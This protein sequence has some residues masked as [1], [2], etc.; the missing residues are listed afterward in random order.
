MK[1]LTMLFLMVLFPIISVAGT[2]N[3]SIAAAQHQAEKIV[4][5]QEKL[6]KPLAQQSQQVSQRYQSAVRQ[7]LLSASPN[8]SPLHAHNTI[9]PSPQ[10]IL[11][12]SL[13]MPTPLLR[14]YL[15]EGHRYH[16]P[17]VIRGL[18]DNNMRQTL[19]RMQEVLQLPDG[20]LLQGGFVM[21]PLWFRRY[22]ITRVPTLVINLPSES[23][24]IIERVSGNLSLKAMLLRIEQADHSSGDTIY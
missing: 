12:V 3:A 2:I 8:I 6:I 14:D 18:L 4:A 17:I 5:T 11:F 7:T 21:D 24:P 1:R 19:K 22:H 20:K 23:S 16:I 9:S 13:G 15:R 10:I